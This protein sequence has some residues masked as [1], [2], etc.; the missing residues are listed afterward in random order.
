MNYYYLDCETTGLDPEDDQLLTV[1]LQKLPNHSDHSRG[2]LRIYTLWDHN[3]SE[4]SLVARVIPY[5][6]GDPFKFIPVG[7][8]LMFDFKFLSTKISKH[9]GWDVSTEYFLA[10]PHLD[11]KHV[12]IMVNKGN[13]KGYQRLVK[14]SGKGS[15]VPKWYSAKQYGKIVDYIVDEADSFM[16]MY[17][18][19]SNTLPKLSSGRYSIA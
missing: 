6:Q 14:K 2:P 3:M 15:M 18:R 10:R 8:N 17:S 11:L 4:K 19:L 13:F 16:K 7:N 1:Q 5:L 12:L 9:F